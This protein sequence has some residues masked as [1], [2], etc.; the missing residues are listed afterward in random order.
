MESTVVFQDYDRYQREDHETWSALM[1]RQKKLHVGGVSQEYLDGYTGLELAE[2]EIVRIE[3]VSRRLET[4]SG[5]T[6]V[7]VTGLIPTKAFFFLLVNKKYPVTISIRKPAEI[8]FSEQPDIFHD[9]CGHLPLL[10]NEKFVKFLT[11]Y[12]VIALK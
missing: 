9:V 12:S 6:L 1:S 7:P 8:D 2:N 11:A 4:I 3:Q 5:W 10:T